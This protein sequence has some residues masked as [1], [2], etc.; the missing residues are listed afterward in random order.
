[1]IERTFVMIKPDHAD[2]VYEICNELG[3]LGQLVVLSK[4][5]S[6]PLEVIQ[7]HYIH[8]KGKSYFDYMTNS[9]VGR[10]VYVAVIQPGFP[11]NGY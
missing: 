4:I 11:G 9:F 5:D 7:D 10:A 8:H 3:K 2:F 6:V 1:M